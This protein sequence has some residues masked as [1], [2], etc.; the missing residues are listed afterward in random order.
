MTRPVILILVGLLMAGCKSQPPMADPFF[1]RTTIPPPPTGSSTGRVAE[2][3]YQAPPF[4][5][6][7]PQSPSSIAPPF[8]QMPGPVP[9][10]VATSPPQNGS[11]PGIT[12]VVSTPRP[13]STI[14]GAA[15]ATR[16]APIASPVGTA[17]PYAPPGGTFNYRG[18]STQ[19]SAPLVPTQP[20][21]RT[22]PPSTFGVSTSRTI[23]PSDD[24]TPRPVDDTLT[25]GGAGGRKPIIQTIQPRA[26]DDAASR[27]ID[28][29]DLPK[30]DDTGAQ[31]R[32]I[33]PVGP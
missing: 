33:Q 12:P 27:R 19:G 14:P 26:R 11:P 5:Q 20:E 29:S 6:A 16:P 9:S 17:S 13:T 18:T 28:I 25:D 30:A 10:G 2:P 31:V 22:A 15:P 24:R 32:L 7:S 21:M 4:V 3:S 23:G 8:V 1:G